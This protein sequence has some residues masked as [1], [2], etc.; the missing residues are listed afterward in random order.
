ADGLVGRLAFEDAGGRRADGDDA[1]AF[2]PGAAQR[3]GGG[4]GDR[5]G[6]F[7]HHVVFEALG[8]DGFEGA[9]ADVEGGESGFD[10]GLL[11]LSFQL[12]GKVQ[13]GG[14]CG[15]SAG[16][17]R[18]DGLVAL[19]VEV[20]ARVAGAVA[21][22]VGREGHAADALEQLGRGGGGG[23]DFADG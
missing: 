5:V 4:R 18:E 10:A 12:F 1:A 3:V 11:D 9:G 13:R 2:G 20:V 8:G 23:V 7:V 6:L 16:L 17:A 15:D 22:D 19:A 14:R 21:L